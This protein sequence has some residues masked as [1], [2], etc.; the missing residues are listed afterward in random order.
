MT[1]RHILLFPKELLTHICSNR[2][3]L[4]P[5]L[6]QIASLQPHINREND[7]ILRG[8]EQ[9]CGVY[10]RTCKTLPYA[11]YLHGPQ[12]MLPPCVDG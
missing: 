1:E 12:E 5:A 7:Y 9:S 8:W 4:P 11:S 2:F 6:A 3:L 10:C